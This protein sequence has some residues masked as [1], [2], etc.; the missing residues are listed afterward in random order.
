MVIN[1]ASGKD[2]RRIVAY[3]SLFGN[4]DKINLVIRIIRGLDSVLH[5]PLT[6]V[7]MPD[8][9]YLGQSIEEILRGKLEHVSLSSLDMPLWGDETDTINFTDLAVQQGVEALVVVGGDGTNRAVAKKSG[10]VPI[11]PVAG[12]TNNTFAWEI[13]PTLVGMAL[14]FF[15]EKAVDPQAILEKRKILRIRRSFPLPPVS[16]LALADVVLVKTDALGSRAVWEPELVELVV[17]TQSDP[18]KIGLSSLVGRV[19]TI[20]WREPRGAWLKTGSGGKLV[21]APL[22]PGLV[23]TF[24]LQQFGFLEVG[25]SITLSGQEGVLALD[26]EREIRVRKKDS[27]E[28]KL[29]FTGP[30]RANIEK[31]M[32]LVQERSV[33]NG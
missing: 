20:D 33:L 8:P 5:R 32:N 9:Y 12:G 31:I 23:K 11:F 13:E 15:L 17:V 6:V 19:V 28:I 21:A 24:S 1:P 3:G 25:S 10:E 4:Q 22:A 18:L 30:I 7:Y 2:I 16:E 27:W 26:G 29:E 14:G